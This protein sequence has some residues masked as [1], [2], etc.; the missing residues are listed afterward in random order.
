MSAVRDAGALR[1]GEDLGRRCSGEGRGR[2]NI[3][4]IVYICIC[5]LWTRRRKTAVCVVVSPAKMLAKHV[6]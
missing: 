1:A 2:D 6:T 5:L 4:Q 3:T